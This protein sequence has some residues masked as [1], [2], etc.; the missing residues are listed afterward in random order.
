MGDMSSRMT[1]TSA[2][3][4]KRNADPAPLPPGTATRLPGAP[5]CLPGPTR[6]HVGRAAACTRTEVRAARAVP[7]AA[8]KRWLMAACI[9]FTPSG[10]R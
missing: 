1:T 4:R 2:A 5:R 9:V 10:A 7:R 3:A 6:A 8:V